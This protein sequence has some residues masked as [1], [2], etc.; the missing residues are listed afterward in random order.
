[1]TPATVLPF[2][3]VSAVQD[4]GRSRPP[5]TDPDADPPTPDERVLLAIRRLREYLEDLS[6]PVNGELTQQ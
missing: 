6:P 1:M 5:A 3:T 2:P 4:S